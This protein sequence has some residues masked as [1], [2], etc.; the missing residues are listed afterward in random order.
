MG[1]NQEAVAKDAFR[2]FILAVHHFT[3]ANPAH[4]DDVARLHRMRKAIAI[5]AANKSMQ[6]VRESAANL[7]DRVQSQLNTSQKRKLSAKGIVKGVVSAASGVSTVIEVA[8]VVG[9]CIS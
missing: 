6:E 2:I 5:C 8:E 1:I 7:L 3:H 4:C 9:C